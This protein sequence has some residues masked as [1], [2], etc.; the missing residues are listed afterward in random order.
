MSALVLDSGALVAA[1][2]DERTVI[3]RLRVAAQ[4][5]MQLRSTG[6]VIAEAWRDQRGRQARLARLLKAID[7]APVDL[8]L[9]RQSGE[10]LGRAG[11]GDAADATVVAVATSGDRILTS[12]PRHIRTLVDASRQAIHVLAC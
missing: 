12:D 10:L 11:T 6:I 1:E 3:A 8:D 2:R 4:S 7:V 5:G 9:G